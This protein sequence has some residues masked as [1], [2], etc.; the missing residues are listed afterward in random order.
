M[1]IE[2]RF[3]PEM[4]S[5]RR[6]SLA[7]AFITSAIVVIRSPRVNVALA[8]RPSIARA[9]MPSRQPQAHLLL[10]TKRMIN[11]DLFYRRAARESV[12][13]LILRETFIK[14]LLIIDKTALKP[15]SVPQQEH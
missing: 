6:S 12:F 13:Y 9:M 1:L 8:A 5:K 7:A 2:S 4:F 14:Y 11:D 3:M 10:C 15:Y